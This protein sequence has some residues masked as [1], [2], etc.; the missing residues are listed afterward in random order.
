MNSIR[1]LVGNDVSS[2]TCQASLVLAMLPTFCT[3]SNSRQSM[4]CDASSLHSILGASSSDNV[5][6]ANTASHLKD[7]HQHQGSVL[8]TT[9]IELNSAS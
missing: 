3:Q 2:L 8:D 5:Q 7:R 1:I 4:S 6:L 9:F